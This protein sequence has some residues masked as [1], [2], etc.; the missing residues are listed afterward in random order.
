[1][2]AAV[3]AAALEDV[4]EAD[5]IGVDIGV[6]ID[7]RMA[8]ARLRREMDDMGKAVTLEQRGHALA[9]GEIELGELEAVEL[10]ELREPR[11]FQ[12]GIVVVVDVVEADHGLAVLQQPPRHM[13]PD[14]PGGT[15]D[16]NGIYSRHR[17][18]PSGFC[19]RASRDFTSKTVPLPPRRSCRMSGQPSSR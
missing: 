11:L 12:L 8:H 2:P 13:K 1:M 10:G 3:V 19:S 16:E 6:R 4:G 7:Q 15:G 14:E 18:M 9:V 17:S 5:E